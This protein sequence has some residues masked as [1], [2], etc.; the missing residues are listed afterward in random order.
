MFFWGG[1]RDR[2]TQSNITSNGVVSNNYSR[3]NYGLTFDLD[4]LKYSYR[5]S[6]DYEHS[7]EGT[8]KIILWHELY[9]LALINI[10]FRKRSF[11]PFL[12]Y[13]FAWFLV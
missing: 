11:L 3:E 2:L 12:K 6:S 1:Q 9:F 8:G 10:L 5:H 4:N 7:I 13:T